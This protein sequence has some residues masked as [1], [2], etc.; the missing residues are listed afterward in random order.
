MGRR[1]RSWSN[2]WADALTATRPELNT[3]QARVLVSGAIGLITSLATN[4]DGSLTRDEMSV[5]ITAMAL[6]TLDTHL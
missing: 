5:T 6:A 2:E 1:L 4:D 3:G